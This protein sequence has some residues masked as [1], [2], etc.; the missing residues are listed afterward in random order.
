MPSITPRGRPAQYA[1]AGPE[2][3]QLELP[4]TKTPNI[5]FDEWVNFLNLVEIRIVA[6]F[7][8]RTFGWHRRRTGPLSVTELCKITR[9]TRPPVIQALNRLRGY[10]IINP[11]RISRHEAHSY[12]L[13]MRPE[14]QALKEAPPPE[15]QMPLRYDVL[16]FPV[17]NSVEIPVENLGGPVAV[18]KKPLPLSGKE[19]FTTGASVLIEFK[20]SGPKEKIPTARKA[21]AVTDSEAVTAYRQQ[22]GLNCSRGRKQDID[23]TVTDLELWR[24]VL[25][26]WGYQKGDKWIKFN[27]LNIG[28]M[29]SEYE[30]LERKAAAQ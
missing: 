2:P 4:Y 16:E 3:Y 27:P 19:T 25:A 11:S 17:E 21:R 5:F 9:R 7:I 24:K 23:A 18:V 15:L 8:R 10:G 1:E 12:E 29:L 26:A 6:A 20:E 30:R 28:H 13:I 14:F 22:F